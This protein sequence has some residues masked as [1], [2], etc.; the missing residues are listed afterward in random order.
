METD[1]NTN[2]TNVGEVILVA[3]ILA[4]GVYLLIHFLNKVI[5]S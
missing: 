1:E 2:A 5:Y 3:I 4:I